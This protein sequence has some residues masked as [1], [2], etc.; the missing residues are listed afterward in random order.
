MNKTVYRISKMDCP[1]E[2]RLISMKL[3]GIEEIQNLQ[4]DI[5]NRKLTVIH[6]NNGGEITQQ[7]DELNLDSKLIETTKYDDTI[8]TETA[9]VHKN[10]KNVL[11]VVLIINVLFFGKG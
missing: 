3:E 11:I 9:L 2:E 8:L 1:S 6:K 7:L 4:F 10:E 5:P